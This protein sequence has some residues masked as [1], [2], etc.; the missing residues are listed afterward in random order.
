MQVEALARLE[1]VE[2]GN[3]RPPILAP[4]FP[5]RSPSLDRA[6]TEGI[7]TGGR[8]RMEGVRCSM[9]GVQ[10]SVFGGGC[11]VVSAGCVAR[12][13][14][15]RHARVV[16][17]R[18]P[19]SRVPRRPDPTAQSQQTKR[20]PR[21]VGTESTRSRPSGSSDSSF[22]LVPCSFL[23]PDLHNVK[24]GRI[25]R[26][27]YLI[28]YIDA[29]QRSPSLSL[30]SSGPIQARAAKIVQRGSGR[31]VLAQAASPQTESAREFRRSLNKSGRY[32]RKPSNDE[33]SLDLMEEHGVGYSTTG[34][35]AQMRAENN[36]WQQ[37][38]VTV[39]LAEAY[40]YCWGVERAVQMAY[41]A[42]K[43]YVAIFLH[44]TPPLL[45][46]LAHSCVPLP[47]PVVSSASQVPRQAPAH[48]QRDHPQPQGQPE[49]RRDGH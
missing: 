9:F 12:C 11:P 38:D 18:S 47:L 25:V 41:E 19:A 42:R 33:A 4:G 37:G 36:Q 21:T 22:R 39:L 10:C 24:S 48:H 17:R 13:A 7:G 31:L 16:A 45:H 5:P 34:L 1:E 14:S 8:W 43:A 30:G 2:S 20:Q 40:G 44:P 46:S 28:T 29:M 23:T 32:T 3:V 26:T 27:V 49:A 35:V 6:S 15:T